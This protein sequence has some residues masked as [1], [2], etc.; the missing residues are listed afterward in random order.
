MR[1][2]RRE[3]AIPQ[4]LLE[5]PGVIVPK[6]RLGERLY[7]WQD[8]VESNTVE[9]YVHKLREKL[10]ADFIDTV[11]GVGSGLIAGR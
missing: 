8:G 7:G 6:D 10:G 11:R 5:R 1:F 3:F 4:V 9:V 2:S